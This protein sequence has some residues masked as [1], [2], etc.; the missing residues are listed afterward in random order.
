[1]VI[2][3]WQYFHRTAP[4]AVG[5]CQPF[6]KDRPLRVGITRW[7][8]FAGAIVANG[9]IHPNGSKFAQGVEF[10]F[11]ENASDRYKALSCEDDKRG[12]DVLWSSVESWAAEFPEFKEKNDKVDAR[13]IMQ[14]AKSSKSCELVADEDI[15]D[16]KELAR[17]R[18]GVP[19]LSPAQWLAQNRITQKKLNPN[20]IYPM[21]SPQKV[22][23]GFLGWTQEGKK[24]DGPF[25][26]AVALCE[27]YLTQAKARDRAH[28][29]PGP[30]D[31]TYILVARFEFIKQHSEVLS[32]LVDQWIKGNKEARKDH[33]NTLDLL[34]Q[35][36]RPD[37]ES[38]F[39][40]AKIQGR[41]KKEL[42]ETQ[43]SSFHEN[44]RFMGSDGGLPE[45]DE[46]F[47]TAS[48]AWRPPPDRFSPE[49]AMEISPL[50]RLEKDPKGDIWLCRRNANATQLGAPYVLNFRGVADADLGN[51]NRPLLDDKN[52]SVLDSIASTLL[53][54]SESGAQAC[55]AAVDL[56]GRSAQEKF[57]IQRLEAE[58]RGYLNTEQVAMNR[59]FIGDD[60]IVPA[61]EHF[62]S[63][64]K[65]HNREVEV[66]VVVGGRK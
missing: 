61:E 5:N 7:A 10:I 44:R 8:G 45:F 17:D 32:D 66:R 46:L 19:R 38:K 39:Q 58:I 14:V 47:K 41:L 3:G 49:D 48:R 56:K 43:M 59:L 50:A 2:C 4:T 28:V 35:M 64:K 27:P 54:N 42:S 9:G 33:E 30:S 40:I 23:E 1:M 62:G 26:D 25:F 24:A 16:E 6:T 18:L 60:N 65:L 29:L 63:S 51:K 52:K 20:R 31:V 53:Q 36:R 13:A 22:L 12:V 34:Y 11:E 55:I 37:N 57:L 21:D 15:T